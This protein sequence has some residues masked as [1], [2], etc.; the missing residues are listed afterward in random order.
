M[1]IK[2]AALNLGLDFIRANKSLMSV[3]LSGKINDYILNAS[4]LP[5][6]LKYSIRIVLNYHLPDTSPWTISE[7]NMF[8]AVQEGI[9]ITG[10]QTG[11]KNFDRKFRIKGEDPDKLLSFLNQDVRKIL[12]DLVQVPHH[13]KISNDRLE[14]NVPLRE[15]GKTLGLTHY[16]RKIARIPGL[17]GAMYDFKERLLYNV[18]HDESGDFRLKNLSILTAHFPEDTKTIDTCRSLLKSNHKDLKIFA[19]KALKDEGLDTLLELIR[20]RKVS[21]TQMTDIILY[22]R[23][24]RYSAALPL[25][26]KN[27]PR[28]GHQAEKVAIIQYLGSCGMLE[29]LPV[30]QA[31]EN[32]AAHYLLRN[33]IQRS[34]ALIKERNN[35]QEYQGRLSLTQSAEKEGGLSIPGGAEDGGL[36]M[37]EEE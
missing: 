3:R 1:F 11:V 29:N 20:S 9:G 15:L 26:L 27:F 34:I 18:I 28:T 32:D 22:L 24:R 13:I 33:E 37:A 30:L 4:V 7:E 5:V 35:A 10:I 14:M 6:D 21:G 17:L 8:S 31:F 19:A 12:L 23:N 16:I 25:L 36:S 2:Q